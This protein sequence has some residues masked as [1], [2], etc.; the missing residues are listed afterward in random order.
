MSDLLSLLT[1]GANG[2][3]AQNAGVAVAT[4]NIAN[5]NTVG[6]SRESVDLE[7]LDGSPDVG[8]VV[9]GAT[10]RSQDTILAG[11]I[12]V[13]SGTLAMS[14]TYSDALGDVQSAL[15]DGGPTI[16]EQLGTLF[17]SLSQV[18]ADPTDSTSRDAVVTSAEQLV[19]G[20]QQKA[21]SVASARDDADSQIQTEAVSATALANQ[22]AAAN[23]AVAKTGDPN[24]LDARDKIANQL[25][26]LV[27]GTTQIDGN[28]QMRYVLDGGAV[29]VDGTHAASLTTTPDP[30]TGFSRLVVSDGASQRDVTA[31]V[32]GGSIG[33]ELKLRDGTLATT[34]NQL[35]QLAYDVTT[36]MNSVSTAN[37][38]LDG[39]TG[40]PMFTA[41]TQVA[42]AA[43][44]MAVD[45]ALAANSKLLAVAAPGAG[46]GDNTGALALFAL[47]SQNVASGGTQTLGDAAVGIVGDV[48][49][50]AS[51]AQ[52]DV[53]QDTIV[54]Q[55]LAGLQD[56]LAGVDTQEE[57]TNLSKF[58]NASNAMIKV[59]STVDDM[60]TNLIENI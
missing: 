40:R 56:S 49:Q 29:L 53:Q 31:Q 28:G 42:G 32:S 21:A 20:I 4:N 16:D 47:G 3:T 26:A 11:R 44:A 8:G 14:Q 46:P 59:V 1:L 52:A 58:E 9:A 36:S 34:A 50:A 10:T 35:D 7:A 39:V 12:Q 6:Y 24:A 54:S 13:S 2:M 30:T 23:A 33:G 22:L 17:S 18:A 19:S 55:N 57:M 15:A 45:P 37:A 51:S 38:G 27:G 41:L 60:L 48:A 25:A 5:A 43:Q